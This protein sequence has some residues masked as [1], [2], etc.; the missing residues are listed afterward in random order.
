MFTYSGI[1]RFPDPETYF[2]GLRRVYTFTY[3]SRLQSGRTHDQRQ[4]EPGFGC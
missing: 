3:T 2:S 1:E 4:R